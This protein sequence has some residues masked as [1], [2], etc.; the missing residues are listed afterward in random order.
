MKINRVSSTQNN[1]NFGALKPI[2]PEIDKALKGLLNNLP[3][4]SQK[5]AYD[6]FMNIWRRVAG[7]Q[8]K[9]PSIDMELRIDIIDNFT[10]KAARILMSPKEDAEYTANYYPRYV[11][12]RSDD[13]KK[14]FF[15]DI[16]ELLSSASAVVVGCGFNRTF[17]GVCFCG[18]HKG[19]P[20]NYNQLIT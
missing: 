7:E 10:G 18:A 14:F 12:C 9:N 20:Y 11:T 16:L 4:E 6:T 8:E 19:A 5:H 13:A 3:G 1:Q 17:M 2:S 15:T